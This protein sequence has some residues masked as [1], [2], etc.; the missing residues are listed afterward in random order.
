MFSLYFH[1]KHE[2]MMMMM[3]MGWLWKWF[4]S[5]LDSQRIY[6]YL[7]KIQSGKLEILKVTYTYETKTWK[8]PK[9]VWF[10]KTVKLKRVCLMLL[11]K[12][13]YNITEWII[14]VN[15]TCFESTILF[16]VTHELWKGE[17]SVFCSY[18]LS[19]FFIF[20]SAD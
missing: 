18:F 10:T 20:F 6:K 8:K 15:S 19:F 12:K 4:G 16:L 11:Y 2:R 3:M 13:M 1:D 5:Q 14:F 9:R 17:K 7:K